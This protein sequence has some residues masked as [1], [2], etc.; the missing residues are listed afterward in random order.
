MQGWGTKC[1]AR[2]G[3]RV[4]IED[5]QCL[6]DQCSY[7]CGKENVKWCNNLLINL[8]RHTSKHR[9]TKSLQLTAKSVSMHSSRTIWNYELDFCAF[10]LLFSLL[11]ILES[12]PSD[13]FWYYNVWQHAK[14]FL[15]WWSMPLMSLIWRWFKKKKFDYWI[16]LNSWFSTCRFMVFDALLTVLCCYRPQ[17]INPSEWNNVPECVLLWWSSLFQA[18]SHH[19]VASIGDYK[20]MLFIKY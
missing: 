13:L 4:F 19:F 1:A 18:L 11:S 5:K 6:A 3:S 2:A 9:K 20:P 8:S 17:W 10:L 14:V 12:K 15:G 7:L 16:Q